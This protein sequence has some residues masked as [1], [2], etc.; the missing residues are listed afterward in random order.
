VT[1]AV[2]PPANPSTP[3]ASSSPAAVPVNER[4][5]A[6]VNDLIR[7]AVAAD[8]GHLAD[9]LRAEASRWQA[10]GATVVVAGEPNRGKSS[11]LNALLGRELMP[12]GANQVTT[13]YSMIR[14]GTDEGITVHRIGQPAERIA[15]DDLHTVATA[16][17]SEGIEGIT[18]ELDHPLLRDGLVVVDTPGVGGLDAAHG[19]VTLAALAAADALVFLLD[20]AEPLSRTEVRFLEE[21]T[22]RLERVLFV[23]SKV[24]RAPGWRTIA[25]DDRT[26]IERHAPRFAGAQIVPVSAR[27]KEVA[28]EFAADGAPDPSLL[29]ES[30]VPALG[31]AL[32]VSVVARVAAVR[33]ANLLR[34]ASSV[35]DRLEA[36]WH[37]AVDAAQGEPE[38]KAAAEVAQARVEELRDT[39]E[40]LSIEITDRFNSIRDL[41]NSEFT[42]ILREL[43]TRFGSE[44]RS[45]DDGIEE[46]HA[47]LRASCAELGERLATEVADVALLAAETLGGLD[48]DLPEVSIAAGSLGDG[49]AE[50]LDVDDGSG[51]D[52][53]MKMRIAS[54]FASGG[55]ML[56]MMGGRVADPAAMGIMGGLFGAGAVL[57][58]ATAA[59]NVRLMRRQ[60]DVAVVR[61]QVQEALESARTEITP[62]VRQQV[63]AAQRELE[64]AVRGAVRGRTKEL[65]DQVATST[66]MARADVAERQR[67]SEEARRALGGLSTRRQQLDGLIAEVA[68]LLRPPAAAG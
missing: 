26:L 66:Q 45:A 6:L 54:S 29:A 57:A 35:L 16:A 13:T 24:D 43:T 11:L 42:R 53:M 51:G 52:Q 61:K 34:L 15:L 2:P 37:A 3:P 5:A 23:M 48:V 59:I 38:A 30:G 64:R 25:D 68:A 67:R 39:S 65:Q 28:D 40:R 58:L 50:H 36:P 56:A 47:E 49:P 46:L 55:M 60:R 41:A 8:A 44:G 4:S 63:L 62:V 31:Q 7:E 12:T 9:R 17:P 14:H 18:V 33:L 1:T 10:K 22:E 20:P 19:R 21:A 27:L 32:Q